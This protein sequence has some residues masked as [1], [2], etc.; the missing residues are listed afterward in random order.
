[1]ILKDNAEVIGNTAQKNGGGIALDKGGTLTLSSGKISSNTAQKYGGGIC[2]GTDA[3]TNDN[4]GT[5]TM[6][7]GEVSNNTA[8]EKSGGGVVVL[9]GTFTMSNGKV[10][11]NTAKETGGGIYGMNFNSAKGEI[12]VS[13]GEI[14]G[15]T[16]N[17]AGTLAGGGIRSSYKLTVSGGTIKTN[18]TTKPSGWGGGISVSEEFTFLGGT[19]VGNTCPGGG[20]VQ[21]TGIHVWNCSVKMSGSAKVDIN[22]DIYLSTNIKITVIAPL[23]GTDPVAR[24]TPETYNTSTKVLDGTPALLN[25]EHGKFT[26][27]PKSGH[28]WSVDSN[29]KL[30]TP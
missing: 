2:I 16:A 14:S 27:T 8:S 13:G 26:V 7:G 9:H 4:T 19:V 5:V 15:N 1:M 24:I 29:G 6:S 11:G 12:T 28:T 20:T 30:K 3:N 10:S 21:G 23:T 17:M 25:S 22:N 18:K